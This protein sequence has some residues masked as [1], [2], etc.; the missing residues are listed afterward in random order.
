M[1]AQLARQ[2]DRSGAPG[3]APAEGRRLVPRAGHRAGVRRVLPR[4][5]LGGRSRSRVLHPDVCGGSHEGLLA[6]HSLSKRSNL[7]GYRCAFV[8]G[9]PALVAELLA[10][11]KNLG[12]QMP[13]PQQAAMIAALDDDAHVEEQHA[14]YA[15]RRR[16]AQGRPRVRPASAI[17]HS[18]ASLYLWATR[19]EDCW[20]TVGVAGRAR[21]PGRARRLLRSRRRPAR[22]RRASPPPTSASA[23][24]STVWLADR[25]AFSGTWRGVRRPTGA[26]SPAQAGKRA[27]AQSASSAS[28]RRCAATASSWRRCCPITA[29]STRSSSSTSRP[30]RS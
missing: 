19:G 22:P 12:L 24:R 27:G 29:C 11:R 18:E 23:P 30:S 9:D 4:V 13:G 21:H 7:A 26:R 6:V 20:D 28:I 15:R 17:D 3:R 14:R 5:R 16:V 1:Y 8:A 10:V 2:P 25:V